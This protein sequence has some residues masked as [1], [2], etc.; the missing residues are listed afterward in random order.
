MLQRKRAAQAPA[1][2]RIRIG[3]ITGL[4]GLRPI[5]DDPQSGCAVRRDHRLHRGKQRIGL[6]RDPHIDRRVGFGH[7][8]RIEQHDIRAVHPPIA[9][10]LRRRG[11]GERRMQ[12]GSA[13][14][15]DA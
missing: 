13:G 15:L 2:G 11:N 14:E 3:G 6:G 5:G 4:D 10:E 9:L 7:T 12:R 1:H 8:A